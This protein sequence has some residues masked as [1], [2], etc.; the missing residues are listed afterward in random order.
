MS[1]CEMFVAYICKNIYYK[2]QLR[3]CKLSESILCYDAP[4]HSTGKSLVLLFFHGLTPCGLLWSPVHTR[5]DIGRLD[6]VDQ[7]ACNQ[8]RLHQAD[9]VRQISLHVT[10][11][12]Q[13]RLENQGVQKEAKSYK[14]EINQI[15]CIY[16][17]RNFHMIIEQSQPHA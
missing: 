11:S 9:Q 5:L 15:F 3:E 4:L 8:V 14:L 2:Y 7:L 6:Q 1:S 16:L 12:D 17:E 13:I 10:R